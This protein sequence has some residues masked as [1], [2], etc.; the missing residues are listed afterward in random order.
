MW[1]L[2]SISRIFFWFCFNNYKCLFRE[3]KKCCKTWLKAEKKNLINCFVWVL[4]GVWSWDLC[5]EASIKILFFHPILDSSRQR[6][7]E[8]VLKGTIKSYGRILAFVLMIHRKIL[9]D[10]DKKL[11]S[12]DYLSFFL[13]FFGNVTSSFDILNL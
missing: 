7:W 12:T 11:H 10:Y 13:F 8:T 4:R 5:F 9:L 3:R 6:Q 1:C 2:V